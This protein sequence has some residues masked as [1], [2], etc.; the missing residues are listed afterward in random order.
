MCC[1]GKGAKEMTLTL[2]LPEALEAELT[3]EA[4]RQGLSLSEYALQLLRA[5][6]RPAGAA[7]QTGAE[8]VAYWQAA[9]LIG[10]RSDIADSQEYARKLRA[11]AERRKW[12]DTD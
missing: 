6:H 8:L 12:D 1:C 2:E 3:A 5:A 4:A 7:P 10:T 11:E 9:G